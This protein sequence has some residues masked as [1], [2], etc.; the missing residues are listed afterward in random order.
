MNI[1]ISDYFNKTQL[2]RCPYGHE[3]PYELLESLQKFKMRC[4]DCIENGE[5]NS[6]CEITLSDSEIREKLTQI[7]NKRLNKISLYEFLILDYLYNFEKTVSINKISTTIDKSED[8]VKL[9]INKLI[10]KDLIS[11]DI[12]ASKALKKE[13]YTITK[14]GKQVVTLIQDLIKK[15]IDKSSN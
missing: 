5:M 15:T 1:L 11:Q 4:P 9:N 3:F 6:F 14:K 13:L 8:T 2:L 10:E 12:E 7:E